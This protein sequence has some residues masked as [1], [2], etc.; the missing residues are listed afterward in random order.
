MKVPYRFSFVRVRQTKSYA[1]AKNVVTCLHGV[2]NVSGTRLGAQFLILAS[3]LHLHEQPC[4][5]RSA[6]LECRRYGDDWW[7]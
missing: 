2:F 7:A 5:T 6:F 1:D 3:I 4:G